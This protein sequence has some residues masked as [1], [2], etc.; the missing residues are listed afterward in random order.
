MKKVYTSDLMKYMVLFESMTQVK[1]LDLVD[2]EGTL[3]FLVPD[4]LVGRAIGR[5]SANVHRL[6][7]AFNRKIKILGFNQKLER[8]VENMIYPV[9]PREITLDERLVTI[10]ASDHKDRGII[11]GR[12]RSNLGFL[13]LL[14]KRFFD[15]D[16]IE[17]R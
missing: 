1:V 8:F 7:S 15:I 12:E 6:E 10:V 2:R 14:T 9:K 5:A 13:T 16:R 4:H 17:V 3:C 11:M